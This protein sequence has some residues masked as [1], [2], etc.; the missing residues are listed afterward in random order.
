MALR[1]SAEHEVNYTPESDAHF[2]NS[3]GGAY[4]ATSSL[5][6]VTMLLCEDPTADAASVC[7]A[8]AIGTST[9]CSYTCHTIRSESASAESLD[10]NG[11]SCANADAQLPVI[12]TI[13]F[14]GSEA[15]VHA[16]LQVTPADNDPYGAPWRIL[17]IQ[18]NDASNIGVKGYFMQNDM[19]VDVQVV[20]SPGS[21]SEKLRFTRDPN[22][23]GC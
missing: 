8:P 13:N 17:P 20:G 22:G 16:V 3:V 7:V 6:E 15:Q 1:C 18:T 9:S 21:L 4:V 10:G 11:C 2:V 12:I 23:S 14:A 19:I 5:G